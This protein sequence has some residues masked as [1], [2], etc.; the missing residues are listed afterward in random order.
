MQGTAQGLTEYKMMGIHPHEKAI[1]QQNFLP[2]ILN[3]IIFII[4]VINFVIKYSSNTV[5]T[6]DPFMALK[7]FK[8]NEFHYI[9]IVWSP[10]QLTIKE[11]KEDFFSVTSITHSKLALCLI[12]TIKEVP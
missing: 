10:T 7:S 1:S 9:L 6:G 5:R 8:P 4:T 12:P 3:I 11:E 2:K